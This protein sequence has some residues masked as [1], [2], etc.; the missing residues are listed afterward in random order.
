[1]GIQRTK[2]KLVVLTIGGSDSGGGAGIQADIKTF[3]GEAA[4]LTNQIAIIL[5]EHLHYRKCANVIPKIWER[6]I[7]T[8]DREALNRF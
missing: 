2:N 1:M 5:S 7:G 3:C 4:H 8:A 6:Q